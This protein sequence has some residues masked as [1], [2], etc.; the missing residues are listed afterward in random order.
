ME[1]LHFNEHGQWKLEK[2]RPSS[3]THGKY[4]YRKFGDYTVRSH[5]TGKSSGPD[6]DPTRFSVHEHKISHKGKHVGSATTHVEAGHHQIGD[7]DAPDEHAHIEHELDG[8]H[9]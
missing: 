5:D 4:K 6:D 8:M 7:F 1:E 3:L 9:D 2:S